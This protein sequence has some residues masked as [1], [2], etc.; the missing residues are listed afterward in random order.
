M[1][2]F[3][4]A[5]LDS[6]RPSVARLHDLGWDRAADSLSAALDTLAEATDHLLSQTGDPN[7]RLA[8]ASPYCTMFGI[9]AG[10]AVMAEAGWAAARSGNHP[11][12]VTARFYLE[13]VV[14][15]ATGLLPAVT[16][17]AADLF[18]IDAALL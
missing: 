10:G 9:V 12:Q 2:G 13:Q 3:V 6:L 11:K 14:P 15:T 8:G 18:A 7:Q 17:G 1:A 5:Y 16:A 4:V